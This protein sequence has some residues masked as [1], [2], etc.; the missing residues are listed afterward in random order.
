MLSRARVRAANGAYNALGRK[1][2]LFTHLSQFEWGREH[3]V[4]RDFHTVSDL[5]RP[6]AS[7]GPLS[8]YP[9]AD[10]ATLRQKL[11]CLNSSR[12][13]AVIHPTSRWSFKEWI[14][15]RWAIVADTLA[16]DHGL[17]VIFS[18]GPGERELQQ[19]TAIR[20]SC[21]IQHS[22]TEGKLSLHELALLQRDAHLFVGVDT[23]AMHLAAAMQT[24]T[25]AIFGP[26]SE[27]SWRPWQCR[28]ELV[29]GDCSCKVTRKFICDKSKPYPCMEK[30][31]VEMV[32]GKISKLNAH[33]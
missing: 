6:G 21:Y 11:P 16:K 3:Q 14:P 12:P 23:L 28:H 20:A 24:P 25:V 22:A 8:F 10:I 27:W 15:E 5:V 4:L 32:L 9:Q 29:L 17:E 18:T 19:L 26:S 33:G 30:I 7:P 13:Y 2:H 1:R 31:S